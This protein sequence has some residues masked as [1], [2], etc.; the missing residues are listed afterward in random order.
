MIRFATI[1]F[2]V[3]LCSPALANEPTIHLHCSVDRSK[4]KMSESETRAA[5]S[6]VNEIW[7][8]HGID[9]SFFFV[10]GGEPE[11]LHVHLTSERWSETV[12][13]NGKSTL[14]P[15]GP[16]AGIHGFATSYPG[17]MSNCCKVADKPHGSVLQ[18][19]N[20]IAH[21]LGHLLTLDDRNDAGL[22]STTCDDDLGK[23]TL[24]QS[25][26]EK[27]SD[28]A[29]LWHL[30]CKL[31]DCWGKKKPGSSP[32]TTGKVPPLVPTP[33][34]KPY[35]DS[36]LIKIIADLQARI[37]V[38][39]KREPSQIIVEGKPGATGPTG[40]I[41]PQGPTGAAGKDGGE[42]KQGPPGVVTVIAKWED[43]KVIGTKPN[44]PSGN[45]VTVPLIRKTTE[46]K[47]VDKPPTA[48]QAVANTTPK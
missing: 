33:G 20:A 29:K 26:I 12:Q 24:T 36:A 17:R 13:V 39:E 8:P 23:M 37:E 14:K 35:D 6:R 41:G 1:L 3:L 2:A 15:F 5:L 11:G 10:S 7:Q 4:S 28:R 47:P 31:A 38:L 44:V 46:P 40:L 48:T 16:D 43:G 9:W 45:S 18:C 21:E 34:T 42:G 19:G 25:E 22:M 30:D 27:A 32:G